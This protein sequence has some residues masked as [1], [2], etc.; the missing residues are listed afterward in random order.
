MASMPS[1]VVPWVEQGGL[2]RARSAAAH[3]DA[4]GDGAVDEDDHGDAGGKCAVA[5]R[6]RRARRKCR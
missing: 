6:D 5:G 2:A 1:T 3:V 4:A